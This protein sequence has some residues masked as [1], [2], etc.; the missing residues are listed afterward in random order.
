MGAVKVDDP[1]RV[2]PRV[3]IGRPLQR[4]PR[5]LFLSHHLPFPPDSGAVARTYHFLRILAR[6]F[7]VSAIC[8]HR[9]KRVPSWDSISERVERLQEATGA[10]CHVVCHSQA[11]A[12]LAS[13]HL[14]SAVV[15]KAYP[16]F[17][18]TSRAFWRYLN[19]SLT[20][21]HFDLIHVDSL[22]LVAYLPALGRRR[23]ICGHHNIES[24]LL[25]MRASQAHNPVLR[26]YL[27]YQAHL[28][29]RDERRWCPR[30]DLNVVV[31]DEDRRRLETL[32]I[33]A[34]CSVIPNGVDTE[35]FRPSS[36]AGSGVVFVGGSDWS[37][38]RDAMMYFVSEILP[39]LRAL[40]VHAEVQWVG[41]VTD[42][43]RR[44]LGHV[45]GFRMVGYVDDIRPCVQSAACCIVPLRVGG[46]TRVKILD[47]WAMGKAVVSTRL[48]CEGLAARDGENILVR[49]DPQLFAEA[50]AQVVGD[51]ELR[52][53]LEGGGRATA[54]KLY[55]WSVIE[56]GLGSTYLSLV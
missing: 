6:Q 10:R 9:A 1:Q 47:A 13:A 40:G 23:V 36:G 25:E 46:G 42:V 22:D 5:L 8:L 52:A 55:S 43:E 2:Q 20:E 29:G 54:E 31:S 11:T 45:T 50:V 27:F 18:N 28:L 14:L 44:R 32:A 24:M 38:N 34:V 56:P 33:G 49:D 41:S 19:R 53:R 37:P 26:R 15:G 30:V 48:G 39:R 21:E 7:D 35:Y 4:R 3:V 17:T 12:H 51:R 16:W